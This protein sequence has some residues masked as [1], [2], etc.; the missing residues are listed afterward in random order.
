M[1]WVLI[2]YWAG[3][4]EYLNIVTNTKEECMKYVAAY[5]HAICRPNP[6]PE[7]PPRALPPPPLEKVPYLVSPFGAPK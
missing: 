5:E 2:V 4:W 1:K 3:A 6:W 7:P